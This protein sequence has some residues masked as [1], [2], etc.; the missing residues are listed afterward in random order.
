MLEIEVKYPAPVRSL[1]EAKL[2]ELG[3]FPGLPITEQ[4]R[5]Y[6]APDRDFAATDEALRIRTLGANSVLTYKGPKRD[7]LTK[8]RTEI[9]VPFDGNGAAANL[10]NLLT[11]LG[12]RPVAD[13]RKQRVIY[14]FSRAGFDMHVCLDD[15]EGVGSYVEL[16]I[17]AEESAYEA[18]RSALLAFAEELGLSSPE[19]RSYLQLLLAKRIS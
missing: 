14:A 9:E 4:D 1:L 10:G 13:V 15:V 3:A 6:N 2:E 12:Y 17:V 16:E 5:Y 11:A 19:R 7:A 18:G 8:T